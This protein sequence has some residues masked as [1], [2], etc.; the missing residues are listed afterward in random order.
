MTLALPPNLPTHRLQCKLLP[1]LSDQNSRL[2][3]AAPCVP[4]LP[5]SHIFDEGVFGVQNTPTKVGINYY[6]SFLHLDLTNVVACDGHIS[7]WEYIPYSSGKAVIAGF[8]RYLFPVF[9]WAYTPIMLV[10]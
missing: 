7:A 1:H 10:S 3:P 5:P 8:W 6:E 4:P 2:I 9:H